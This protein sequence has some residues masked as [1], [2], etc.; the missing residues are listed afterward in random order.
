VRRPIRTAIGMLAVLI[1]GACAFDRDRPDPVD[2]DATASLLVELLEPLNGITVVAGRTQTVR[3]SARDL[4]GSHLRGVGFLVRRFGSGM[5]ITVDS[6]G[7]TFGETGD[8]TREFV[9]TVPASLPTNTQL[10]IFGIAY[11]PQS[12]ASLSTPRYVVV[13]QC[14]AGQNC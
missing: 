6:V 10:D 13:A 7:L 3:V 2:P 9:F 12:Q 8:A 11:G 1:A 4:D 14:Q 5:A